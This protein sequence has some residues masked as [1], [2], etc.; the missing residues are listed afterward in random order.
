MSHLRI[1]L[2]SGYSWWLLLGLAGLAAGAVI[3]FYRRAAVRSH[4][5][6]LVAMIA[7]RI[8]LILMVV[9]V[10]FRPSCRFETGR[11]ERD[12]LLVCLDRS[13]SMGISDAPGLPA[14]FDRARGLLS[15]RGGALDE[16]GSDFDVRLWSFDGAPHRLAED[17]DLRSESAGGEATNL[18]AAL[19]G[20]AADLQ[21][22][23]LAGAVVITDG[24]DNSGADAAAEIRKLGFPVYTVGAGT[25]LSESED[26]K[27]VAVNSV[28][29]PRFAAVDNVCEVRVGIDATGFR[30]RRIPV[31]LIVEDGQGEPV[32]DQQESPPLDGRRGDQELVLR[33]TPSKAGSFRAKVSARFDEAER[34]RENNVQEFLLNVT[35]PR[36]RVLYVEGRVRP[37]YGFLRRNWALDPTVEVTGVY[38]LKPGTFVE[39]PPSG[40][41]RS[42]VAGKFFPESYDEARK[43][44]VFVLG[45]IERDSFSDAQLEALRR[46][47]SEG[48]G[49]LCLSGQASFGAGGWAGSKLAELL[50]VDIAPPEARAGAFP[51]Q[52]TAAG[53]AHPVFTG[54]GDFF[55]A[56][57]A[58]KLPKLE[59]LNFLGAAKP[60]AEVLAVAPDVPDAA[61]KPRT[62][63]AVQRYGKGRSAV[64]AAGPTWKWELLR[65]QGRQTPYARF[66][67]QL[68]RWLASEEVKRQSESAGVT[69]HI[70]RNLYQPGEKVRIWA[71][72]HG[73]GGRLAPNARVEARI[74]GSGVRFQ[75]S[76]KEPVPPLTPDTRNPTPGG[77]VV[78][79]AV[80]ESPGQFETSWTPPGP[81]SYKLLV[82]AA[83]GGRALGEVTLEFRVG[84]PNLEFEKLD[85]NDRLLRRIADETRGRYFELARLDELTAALTGEVRATR[86]AQVIAFYPDQA[87]KNWLM[88]ALFIVAAG[89]EWIIRKQLRMS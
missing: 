26:F 38:R 70:D 22:E 24:E 56:A 84:K 21:G 3:F 2:D 30:G 28:E 31:S 88:V 53:R 17:K 75:V 11:A 10:L 49:L 54:C 65:G 51:L 57:D 37:E 13:R 35:E 40:A 5:S 47:V 62:V 74:E 87:W 7:L 66:W 55:A 14:R 82:S 36:L 78:L 50:P 67:G 69:A 79:A 58:G 43:F 8:G 12:V 44:N 1:A 71:E 89:A 18:A 9:A 16:L 6:A 19:A 46:A 23:R 27:D 39:Q 59:F 45:D 32:K 25:R 29:A 72:A 61:G 63:L 73:D 33:F 41:A 20:A 76:G 77:K 80:A 68:V 52:L 64:F 86:T 15:G 85:L 34:I 42:S 83:D 4:R 48:A 81:G 60:G